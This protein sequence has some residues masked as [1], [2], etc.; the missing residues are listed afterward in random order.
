MFRLVAGLDKEGLYTVAPLLRATL[1]ARFTRRFT[2]VV[3]LDQPRPLSFDNFLESTDARDFPPRELFAAAAESFAAA[4]RALERMVAKLRA[5]TAPNAV[6]P[7]AARP[8]PPSRCSTAS[9]CPQSP[10]CARGARPPRGERRARA[11]Q[12]KGLEAEEALREAEGSLAVASYNAALSSA[13]RDRADG[14]SATCLPRPRARARSAPRAP[15][16]A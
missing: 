15:A 10:A 9:R 3:R 8:A 16:G 5:S 11:P 7:R 2:P 12:D 1:P 13:L 14:H 6:R 4:R